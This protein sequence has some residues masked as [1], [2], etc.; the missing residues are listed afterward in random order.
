[1]YGNA[2]TK[3]V[4]VARQMVANPR[5]AMRWFANRLSG[6]SPLELRQPW[7]TYAAIDF[8]RSRIHPGMRVLEWGAG[9][10]TLFFALAACVITSVET[11]KRW[12]ELVRS[13][14]IRSSLS[15][16]VDLR[17]VPLAALLDG[18]F[19]AYLGCACEADWD[20]VLVDGSES[21]VPTRM[22]CLSA[23]LG[24]IRP[25]GLLI[26]DDAWR[27]AYSSAPGLLREYTRHQFLG[28]GPARLPV[29]KT[30]VYIRD[31]DA[32]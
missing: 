15:A 27:S 22:R 6:K 7:L 16:A 9:G 29:G 14:L 25:G 10:S 3:S 19:A 30:D 18:D 28:L 11:D 32:H 26:L 21:Q 12:F 2:L 8:L 17:L 4:A 23:A 31:T 24:H 20:V 5:E 13:H 1:M